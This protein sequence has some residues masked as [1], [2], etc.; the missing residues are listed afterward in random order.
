V[1]EEALREE[2]RRWLHDRIRRRIL[3]RARIGRRTRAALARREG[4]VRERAAV[5]AGRILAELAREPT[6][7]WRAVVRRVA[8]ELGTGGR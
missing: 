3:R 1:T 7:S 8:G 5:L 4:A 6:D 2:L